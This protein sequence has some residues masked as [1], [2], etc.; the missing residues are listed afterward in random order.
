[1]AFDYAEKITAL[2]KKAEAEGVTAEE[3][4]ILRQKAYDLMTKHSIDQAM[5]DAKRAKGESTAEDIVTAARALYAHRIDL[6]GRGVRLLGVGVS[7]L[8]AAGTGPRSLFPDAESVRARKL[9]GIEDAVRKRIGSDAVT[10]ESLV[11]KG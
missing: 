9:A 10:R 3:A 4:D 2:L 5:I 6:S 8:V 7:G 1:M 11:K